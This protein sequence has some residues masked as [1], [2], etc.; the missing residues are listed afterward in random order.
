MNYIPILKDKAAEFGALADLDSSVKFGLTPFFDLL[1]LA[2]SKE[3]DVWIQA[4]AKN[5]GRAWN[6]S[7]PIYA[8]GAH[9]G[10][11][12][13]STGARALESL[14]A[15]CNDANVNIIPVTGLGRASDYQAAIRDI[16]K[17]RSEFG[18]CIRLASQDF[19]GEFPVSG[20]SDLLKDINVTEEA[21]DLLVDLGA[22]SLDMA[23]LIRPYLQSIPTPN[24]WRGITLAATS[25]PEHLGEFGSESL[26]L[27]PR[28]EWKAWLS[29]QK[30]K[31][32]RKPQFSDYCIQHPKL[33][34]YE[35]KMRM[36][37]QLR[38]TTD[39]DW[40]IV[41]G[42]STREYGFEQMHGLCKKLVARPEFMGPYFSAGDEW[43]AK[44]AAREVG[45]GNATTWRKAGTT[46]HLT[47]VVRQLANLLA[48]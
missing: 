30:S 28:L 9:L 29:L 11:I 31:L 34:E 37:A 24:K 8:D 13:T 44:C 48:I 35:P 5:L 1:P 20:L 46:H 12:R 25:F 10:A 2:P 45:P 23:G 43:I 36:S 19:G 40:L 26:T 21:T 16:V 6:I 39:A 17:I 41:R 14:V 33:A 38:Y 32:P 4:L 22:I 18:V 7:R 3:P 15:T 27:T 42:R 47:A